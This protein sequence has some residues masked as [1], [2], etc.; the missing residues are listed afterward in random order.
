MVCKSCVP[1]PLNEE[2]C[3]DGRVPKKN[4][5]CLPSPLNEEICI[6]GRVPKKN[7][8]CL[9]QKLSSG[10]SSHEIRDF[11]IHT[12]QVISNKNLAC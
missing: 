4:V 11:Q 9:V 12:M 1:S 5:V 3:V 2:I 7:V 6:D 10:K 8:V